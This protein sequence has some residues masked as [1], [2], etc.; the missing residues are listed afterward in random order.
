MKK[1]LA[2]ILAFMLTLSCLVACGES[3]KDTDTEGTSSVSESDKTPD[4]SEQEDDGASDELNASNIQGLWRCE[5][6][7]GAL[8]QADVDLKLE[9]TYNFLGKSVDI[10]IDVEKLVD[11]IDLET[12]AK[13]SGTS[14]EEMEKS[15]EEE[16]LTMDDVRDMI[17]DTVEDA[18]SEI[19]VV[20]SAGK[21]CASMKYKLEDG[22]IY[23]T[24]DDTFD[25]EAGV[26]YSYE[27]GVLTLGALSL[28]RE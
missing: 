3:S 1:L 21:I 13:I 23:L 20:N 28:T 12:F 18:L 15:M 14:V 4:D 6:D 17:M 16:G 11:S 19:G 25:A 10:I 5:M 26:A 8:F 27:D 9:G 7:A 24:E 22:E 2:L